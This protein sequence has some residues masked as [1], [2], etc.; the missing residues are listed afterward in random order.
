M[1]YGLTMRAWGSP[2]EQINGLSK[3]TQL[4]D[5]GRPGKVSMRR[6]ACHQCDACWAGDRYNC[7]NKAYTGLPGIL[8]INRVTVPAAAAVRMERA[9]LNR[10][11]LE[12]AKEAEVR[13]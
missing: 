8:T 3:L 7:T 4:I 5:I 9:E 13:S 6:A 10:Q 2:T 11:G 12:R 1:N